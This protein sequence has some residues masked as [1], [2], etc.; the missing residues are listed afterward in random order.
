MFPRISVFKNLSQ[1]YHMKELM[2]SKQDQHNKPAIKKIILI[3][4]AVS[5]VM[6]VALNIVNYFVS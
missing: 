5:T 1:F 4:L 6:V 3:V 2:V